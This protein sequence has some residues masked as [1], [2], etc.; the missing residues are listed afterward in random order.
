MLDAEEGSALFRLC[1]ILTRIEDASHILIWA[2]KNAKDLTQSIKAKDLA[3]ISVIEL[4]RLKL[5]FQP[6][7]DLD[8]TI[9]CVELDFLKTSK[10]IT[11]Y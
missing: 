6:K 11:Y 2:T 4:P 3:L 9:R 5:R 7:K 1:T 8:G 10:K